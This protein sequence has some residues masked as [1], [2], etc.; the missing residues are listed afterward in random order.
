MERVEFRLDED[1]MTTIDDLA[2]EEDISK[3]QV[4]RDLIDYALDHTTDVYGEEE[5]DEDTP[6][7]LEDSEEEDEEDLDDDED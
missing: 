4:I 7:D 2:T 3:A 6:V 1:V 5:P